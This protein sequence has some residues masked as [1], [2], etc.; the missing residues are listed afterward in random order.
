[1][2]ISSV[3]YNYSVDGTATESVSLVET[4]DLAQDSG[5]IGQAQIP[6]GVLAVTLLE[7]G[8]DG[9]TS[10]LSLSVG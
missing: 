1:M 4:I 2:F 7:K 10:R 8:I 9:T 3:A 5:V 6:F